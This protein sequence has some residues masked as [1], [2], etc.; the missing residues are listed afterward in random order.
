MMSTESKELPLIVKEGDVQRE[1]KMT[2]GERGTNQ[3][4]VKPF[5][6]WERVNRRRNERVSTRPLISVG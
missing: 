3:N 1:I 5:V 4:T 6:G 2:K